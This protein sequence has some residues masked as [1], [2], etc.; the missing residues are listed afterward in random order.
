[1][2]VYGN[3]MR[4]I[5]FEIVIIIGL[6]LLN[7]LLAMSEMAI[8][9]AR[10]SKLQQLAEAGSRR[11]ALALKLAEKPE[12]LLSAVQ[13]GITLIGIMAGVVGGA[14]I[15][16]TLAMYL[17]KIAWVGNYSIAI[18]GVVV[19]GTITFLSLL[20]GE[21]V[22]KRIALSN[23]EKI[24]ARTARFMVNIER[25]TFPLVK[26]LTKSTNGILRFL[27]V[28]Q[29]AEPEVTEEEVK[30]LLEEGT[31]AGIFEEVE[32]DMVESVLTLDNRPISALMT[33]R[34]EID[35]YDLE[36]PIEVFEEKIKTSARSVFP[37]AH[38]TLDNVLGLIDV[39]DYLILKLEKK[40]K[41]EKTDL[42][43]ILRNS[44]FIVESTPILKVV[45]MFKRTG[46]HIA[47]IIDEHGVVQGLVTIND[48]LE[49]IVGDISLSGEP[50]AIKREDGSWLIDGM[51]PLDE[52]KRIFNLDV[53]AGE[54][55]GHYYTMGGL[56][57][58]HMGKAPKAGDKFAWNNF[59]FE[60]MDMDGRR[61]D[62]MLVTPPTDSMV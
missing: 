44:L 45:E 2:L 31:K 20:L 9:A 5:A 10:K 62:K 34:T 59:T 50:E 51:L 30:V 29:V 17:E 57:V 47:M 12:N 32:Q 37:V 3:Y 11:S 21:L 23:P 22:P 16:E 52:F 7:G 24:A 38:D 49:A 1:M 27:G 54:E 6:V 19:V 53:W 35:W 13:I 36:D 4:E 55:E 46:I 15:A 8:I 18:A 58:V 39:K 42:R 41:K 56:L 25:L 33:P 14:T 43:E 48:V 60:V 61:V 28:R 26:I 40:S